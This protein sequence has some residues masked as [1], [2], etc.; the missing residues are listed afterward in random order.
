MST[1]TVLLY[2]CAAAVV[3]P[4][5]RVLVAATAPTEQVAGPQLVRRI[6]QRPLPVVASVLVVLMA[7]MAVV[8]TIAPAV[9]HH[10][11]RVPDG[12][13]WRAP[14]ALLVES[15]GWIQILFN[16]AALI[17]VAPVAERLFG[18]VRMLLVYLVSGV[19]AQAVS[20]A[21]WSK[22]GAGNSVAICGL[23]GA[24]AVVYALRGPDAALRKLAL[25]VPLAGIVLCAITNNHGVGVLVGCVLGV[26]LALWEGAVDL[27]AWSTARPGEPEEPAARLPG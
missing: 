23:V 5:M 26:G 20:L 6:W 13:W 27:E 7:A 8:Q 22:H 4:G 1:G 2:A 10:L 16:L 15:S 25:L 12:P 19:A 14:S 3:V 18:S 9:L 17:A 11:E 24:L 21:S